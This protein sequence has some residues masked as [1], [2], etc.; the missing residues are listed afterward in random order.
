MP[1][2]RKPKPKPEIVEPQVKKKRGRPPKVKEPPME[3]LVFE[4]KT[5]EPKSEKPVIPVDP[6]QQKIVTE[7]NIEFRKR[8]NEAAKDATPDNV[9]EKLFD[10]LGGSAV[11]W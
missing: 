7:Q 8:I 11:D 9:V 6:A 10:V 3:K 5:H 4:T 2:G 1:R